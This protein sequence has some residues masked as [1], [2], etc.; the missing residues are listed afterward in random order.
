VANYISKHEL[1]YRIFY[2]IFFR[3]IANKLAF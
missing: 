2:N 3:I 1:S